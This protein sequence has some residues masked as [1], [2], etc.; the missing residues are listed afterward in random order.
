MCLAWLFRR[1][2]SASW[3]Q[4]YIAD[5]FGALIFFLACY[6]LEKILSARGIKAAMDQC[7]TT[8]L[9]TIEQLRNGF[10]RVGAVF[11]VHKFLTYLSTLLLSILSGSI[12]RF[13]SEPEAMICSAATLIAAYFL[14]LAYAMHSCRRLLLLLLLFSSAYASQLGGII[15]TALC[16]LAYVQE[17][18]L[19][20]LLVLLCYI[21]LWC[22][23]ALISDD[24]AAQLAFKIVNTFTTL[25]AIAGNIFIPFLAPSSEQLGIFYEGYSNQDFFTIG[26]NLFILPLVAA[27]YLATLTK[28]AQIYL[29]KKMI[30]VVG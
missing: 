20:L 16:S 30:S 5:A 25:A 27:G 1:D 15:F 23:A 26:F 19:L 3:Y 13:S 18:D 17:N 21:V 6:I 8:T 14:Y 7:K 29:R 28:D 10:N 12:L 11:R 24:D 22:F 9:Q 4:R 2:F